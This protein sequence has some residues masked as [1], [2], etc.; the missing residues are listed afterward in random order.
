MKALQRFSTNVARALLIWSGAIVLAQLCVPASALGVGP[1]TPEPAIRISL[2]SLGFQAPPARV[3]ALGGTLVTV[4]FVDDTHLLVTFY[5]RALM[6]RLPDAQPEDSDGMVAAQLLELPSGKVLGKTEWRLRDRDPYL[7]AIG[8]GRFL[9][10]IRNR[11]TLLDPLGNLA[12]GDPF[13]Q[14]MFGEFKRRIGYLTVSPGG[15]LLTVET[16]PPAKPKLTGGAASTAA[17]AA[18]VPKDKSTDA[19]TEPRKPEVQV[20]FFRLELNRKE[21]QAERLRGRNAGGLLTQALVSVPVSSEGFIGATK[22]SATAYDF[23]FI[24]HTGNKTELAA[25]DTTCTPHP[26]FVSR[27]EF[28]ALGCHGAPDKPELGGFNLKGEHAWIEVL[29]G[30]HLG[31]IILGSPASGRFVLS[32]ITL[33]GAFIDPQ[34]VVPEEMAGQ[35]VS[36][37]QNHD[38]R[39]LLKLQA[40]PIQRAG[41][42]FDL[43]PGGMEMVIVRAGNVEIYRLPPLTPKDQKQMKLAAEMEPSRND[44]RIVLSDKARN[45]EIVHAESTSQEVDENAGAGTAPAAE[46]VSAA[47]TAT[48]QTRPVEK[49]SP[50]A[51]P[52]SAPSETSGDAPQEHRK[53]PTLYD[54]DHPRKP[55]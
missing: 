28:V 5:T 40:S 35:E 29:A 43:S 42:N 26:Y 50:G 13:R 7:W 39:L 53:P 9:L 33:N 21:G 45:H 38:G 3:A 2:E 37:R 10:R 32:R 23:D 31:P 14:E 11:L 12:Q 30:D 48:G 55:E 24:T 54:P 17:L 22:E 36:V 44:A 25:F 16:L 4:N 19:P 20:L 34:N 46:Q 18:T 41:G 1:R 15:D 6:P 52:V 27:S 51:A 8:H 49:N 47:S